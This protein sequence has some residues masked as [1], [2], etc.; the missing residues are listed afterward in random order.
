MLRA[1]ATHVPDEVLQFLLWHELCHHVLP[2]HGHDAEFYR[3]LFLWP[4][5][6]RLDFAIDQLSEQ[7]DTGL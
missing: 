3:L 4:D 7:Y 2:G 6:T 1:P 5:A